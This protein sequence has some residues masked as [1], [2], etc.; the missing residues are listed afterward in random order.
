MNEQ[1]RELRTLVRGAYDV[2]KLRI[3]MGNRIVGNFKAKL[4]QEPGKSEETL[5]DEAKDALAVLRASFK[6]ITDGL[7]KFPT[8]AGF[9]GDEVISSYT[10]LVLIEQY[11]E[12]EARETKHFARLKAVLAEFTLWRE[13][14]EGVRGIG[15]AMAGVLISEIDIH[16]AKYPS[17]LWAY[18]GYD[19]VGR[20]RFSHVR[21]EGGTCQGEIYNNYVMANVPDTRP[22]VAMDHLGEAD[23]QNNVIFD[24]GKSLLYVP[25]RAPSFAFTAIYTWESMGGRSRRRE[26]LVE[27]E[28]TDKNGK[29]ATRVGITF[30]PWLKT[31]LR[32]LAE[33]FIKMG[34]DPYRGIY[35]DYKQ[36]LES[37]AKYG[38]ANDGL[39]ED[40]KIITSKGRRHA[41]AMRYMVKMFLIDLYKAWRPLEG[42]PVSPPYHEAKLGMRHTA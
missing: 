33:L 30:N 14:L 20:W 36:R 26:H 42:L 2:Q 11:I 29:A 22:L 1:R 27:R 19:V 17:S 38:I 31:K 5:D 21:E 32:V 3:E 4:G 6:K 25:H 34:T 10:E 8:A 12:L 39:L 40:G 9:E 7:K 35:D 24:Q 37:H 13:F 15:P 16:K 28:Y 23:D 41:M 18:S